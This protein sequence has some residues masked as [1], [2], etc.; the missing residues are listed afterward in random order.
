MSLFK[1]NEGTH[2]ELLD[3][4]IMDS[5]LHQLNRPCSIAADSEGALIVADD[6]ALQAVAALGEV[7]H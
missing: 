6:I 5:G 3:E 1:N 7:F 4:I 2:K